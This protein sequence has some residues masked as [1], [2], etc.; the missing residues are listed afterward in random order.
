MTTERKP[1]LHLFNELGDVHH[2]STLVWFSKEYC[3]VKCL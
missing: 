3:H 1:L 2:C